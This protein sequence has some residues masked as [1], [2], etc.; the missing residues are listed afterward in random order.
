MALSIHLPK[1]FQ[2]TFKNSAGKPSIPGDLLFFIFFKD[3]NNSSSFNSP[4]IDVAWSFVILLNFISLN[5][6][7]R[8]NSFKLL[9]CARYS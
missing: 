3:S 7:S 4:S 2:K 6:I 5:I 1:Y 9:S 8:S